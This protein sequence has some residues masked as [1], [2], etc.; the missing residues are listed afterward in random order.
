[1][2]KTKVV[3]PYVFY[4]DEPIYDH[5]EIGSS[6]ATSM[7]DRIYIKDFFDETNLKYPLNQL[8]QDIQKYLSSILSIKNFDGNALYFHQI[9]SFEMDGDFYNVSNII[10][11]SNLYN[12]TT[13]NKYAGI[14]KYATNN[15]SYDLS[16]LGNLATF[17]EIYDEI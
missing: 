1:M 2:K 15:I 16:L 4:R 10:K 3:I 7:G 6:V 9:I 13:I 8:M 11:K 14:D 12:T 17:D 5:I